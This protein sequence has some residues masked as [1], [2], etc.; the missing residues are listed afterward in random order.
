MDKINIFNVQPE[1]GVG[2]EGALIM[3]RL[4]VKFI[5]NDPIDPSY[6]SGKIGGHTGIYYI[7]TPGDAYIK[8]K[9]SAI[10][11]VNKIINYLEDRKK[12]NEAIKKD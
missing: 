9:Q 6:N 1:K 8:G 11:Q 4:A 10:R 5:E 7:G 3:L 12:Q 2:V